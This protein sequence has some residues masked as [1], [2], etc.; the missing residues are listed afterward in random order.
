MGTR[1][2]KDSTTKGRPCWFRCSVSMQSCSC[3]E[4]WKTLQGGRNKKAPAS[5][6]IAWAIPHSSAF[7]WDA[8]EEEG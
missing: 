5:L 1:P 3:V 8:R 7:S 4:P 2:D 6:L